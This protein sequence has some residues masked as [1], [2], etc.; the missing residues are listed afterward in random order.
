MEGKGQPQRFAD[1]LGVPV[2]TSPV[3]E[4]GSVCA[5]AMAGVAAGAFEGIPAGVVALQP[6]WRA[7][8]PNPSRAAFVEARYDRYCQL[9]HALDAMPWGE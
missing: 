7:Y 9:A 5:A 4:L 8:D 1:V 2:L 3:S 6:E